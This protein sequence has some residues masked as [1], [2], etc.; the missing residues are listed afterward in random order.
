ME[1]GQPL[2]SVNYINCDGEY[3]LLNYENQG[4]LLKL[5]NY[6]SEPSFD[7]SLENI[8]H[9]FPSFIYNSNSNCGLNFD[10]GPDNV[11]SDDQQFICIASRKVRLLM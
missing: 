3:L 5:E 1:D 2:T 4:G 11:V 9:P 10:S 6:Y 8:F 7:G